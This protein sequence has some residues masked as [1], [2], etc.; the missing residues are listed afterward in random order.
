MFFL[1]PWV[2][3]ILT[4]GSGG[5][6]VLFGSGGAGGDSGGDI[7]SDGEACKG[8]CGGRVGELNHLDMVLCIYISWYIN[9]IYILII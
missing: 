7:S 5:L 8:S 3:R 9:D 6:F 2:P 1:G 4:R